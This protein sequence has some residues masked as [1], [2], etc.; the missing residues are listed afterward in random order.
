MTLEVWDLRSPRSTSH[1]GKKRVD[2]LGRN[3]VVETRQYT[4]NDVFIREPG[5]NFP[6]GLRHNGWSGPER[7]VRE[8]TYKDTRYQDP[9]DPFSFELPRTIYTTPAQKPDYCK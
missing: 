1:R 6:V 5:N 3:P 2:I 4:E 8:R 9:D 7:I